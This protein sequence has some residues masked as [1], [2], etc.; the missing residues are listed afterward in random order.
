M[1]S[2]WNELR[3]AYTG[4]ASYPVTIT[5]SGSGSIAGWTFSAA[6][7][8]PDATAAAGSPTAVVTDAVNRKVLLTLPGQAAA[9]DYGWE[10]RR[11]DDSSGDVVAHGVIEVTKSAGRA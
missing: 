10:V 11:T 3:P 6:M 5:L 7:F 4:E 9:G 1:S 8:D 2:I